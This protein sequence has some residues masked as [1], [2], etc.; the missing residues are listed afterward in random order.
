MRVLPIQSIV[1]DTAPCVCIIMPT[2]N[3]L[4]TTKPRLKG[5]L[6]G[7][8]AILPCAPVIKQHLRNT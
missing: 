5:L 3:I 7:I 4:E 8:Y 1:E 6:F 2:D